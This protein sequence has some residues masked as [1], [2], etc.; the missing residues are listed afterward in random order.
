MLILSSV[1]SWKKISD[2]S[3]LV[4][5]GEYNVELL[6]RQATKT[7]DRLSSKREAFFGKLEDVV[8]KRDITTDKMKAAS[9]VTIDLPKFCGYD[10]KM[11]IF[12]FK[13]EFQKHVEPKYQK[14]T[15]QIV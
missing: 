1:L 6:V 8:L 13:S 7:R 12:T 4:S 14:N 2:L 10:S 9:E 11:D 5:T 15:S 3:S